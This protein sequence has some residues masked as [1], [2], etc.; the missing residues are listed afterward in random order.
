M[1]R[2]LLFMSFFFFFFGCAGNH[3][4][5]VGGGYGEIEG[6]IEYC[7]DSTKSLESGVPTFETQ[8]E[9]IFGFN[10]DTVEKIRDILKEKLGILSKEKK[11]PVRE[12]RELIEE[13]EKKNAE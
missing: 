3:C 13:E 5:S 10:L 9:T 4:I 6:N 2:L 11:H 8:D 7:Y 1:K 12:I